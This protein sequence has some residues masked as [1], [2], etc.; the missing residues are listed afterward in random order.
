MPKTLAVVSGKGGVGTTVVAINLTFVLNDFGRR[1]LLVDGDIRKPNI[2]IYLGH[3]KK[4]GSI[5]DV[6][7]G[8]LKIKDVVVVH[9]SGLKYIAG[10]V[11]FERNNLIKNFKH[12]ILDEIKSEELI[13]LDTPGGFSSDSKKVLSN[14]DYGLLV[15]TPQYAAVADASK[16]VRFCNEIKIKMVGVVVNRVHGFQDEMS[17]RE[18]KT[19]LGLPVLA[20]IPEDE[21]FA[22]AS[23][24]ML[25]L[26][27]LDPDSKSA[28]KFK[29]I[30]GKL[31]GVNYEEKTSKKD[32]WF[33][34]VLKALGMK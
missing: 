25:P 9:P 11:S 3:P 13:V 12:N 32:K 33:D 31:L 19:V 27:F 14:V 28:Q 8:K 5:H 18:I 24:R 1:V 15:T 2:A 6:L 23:R 26:S 4:K 34:Y 29:T 21:G 7:D 30:A 22:Q 10:D 17:S 16:M 20:E